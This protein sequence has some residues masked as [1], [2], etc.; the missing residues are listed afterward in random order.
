MRR[1]LTT[2]TAVT[3]ALMLAGAPAALAR[4]ADGVVAPQRVH[5]TPSQLRAADGHQPREPLPTYPP[6]TE[7]LSAP[8]D[9][10]GGVP[11]ELVFVPLGLGLV[12]GAGAAGR[13]HAHLRPRVR[14]TIPGA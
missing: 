6:T 4:P 9:D 11:W 5:L 8:S 12:A 3:A 2:T 10:G 7:P 1:T 13:R 14:P